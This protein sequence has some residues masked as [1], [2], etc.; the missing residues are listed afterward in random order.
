[1]SLKH[2]SNTLATNGQYFKQGTNNPTYVKHGSNTVWTKSTSTTYTLTLS[3]DVNSYGSWNKSSITGIASGTTVSYTI[4]SNG[5]ATL[6]VGGQSAIFTPSYI[7]EFD[8]YFTDYLTNASGTVTSNKTV[9]AYTKLN[10]SIDVYEDV[11]DIDPVYSTEGQVDFDSSPSRI[12]IY[13][14]ILGFDTSQGDVTT[15][16]DGNY[17]DMYQW[18]NEYITTSDYTYDD[19]YWYYDFGRISVELGLQ[20]ST[21]YATLNYNEMGSNGFTVVEIY[22]VRAI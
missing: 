16:I 4:A 14:D 17:I 9:T 13:F 10:P 2:G 6:T 3:R 19:P 15:S 5:V 8:N 22:E 21:L 1:M 7:D 12:R 18:G 11:V 20:G